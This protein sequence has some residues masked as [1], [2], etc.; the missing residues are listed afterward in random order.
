VSLL[1]TDVI[2]RFVQITCVDKHNGARSI[3]K[4]HLDCMVDRTQRS[5]KFIFLAFH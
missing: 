3:I 5:W 4:F 1:W 2:Y